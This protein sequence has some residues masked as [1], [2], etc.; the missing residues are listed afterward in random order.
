MRLIGKSV[1]RIDA[2]G[3]VTGETQYPGDINKPNQA[4]AKILFAGRPHAII[5]KLD[6]GKAEKLDGVIG[7]FT[8]MKGLPVTAAQVSISARSTGRTA[9]ECVR[10]VD[11]HGR[12]LGKLAVL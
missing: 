1:K 9:N 12:K 11:Q 2:V 8:A 5:K 4:Y 7:I 3:K 6:T 10:V